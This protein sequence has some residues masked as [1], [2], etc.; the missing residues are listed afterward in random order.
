MV[1]LY[2]PGSIA[3]PACAPTQDDVDDI[4][5]RIK[6]LVAKHGGGSPR[7]RNCATFYGW[8]CATRDAGSFGLLK[9]AVE[10]AESAP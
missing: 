3:D 4:V 2:V 6:A 7:L 10:E 9:S 5:R 1:G 8:L